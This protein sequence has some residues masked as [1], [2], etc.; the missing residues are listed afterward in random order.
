MQPYLFPYIGYFQLINY[1]DKFVFY[2]DVNY[3]KRGWINRNKILTNQKE[4]LFTVPLNKASQNNLIKDTKISNS[5]YNVWKNKTLSTVVQF[6][7]EAKYFEPTYQL[8]SSVLDDKHETISK[9]SINSITS[10]SNYLGLTTDF[11]ISSESYNNRNIIRADRLIDIC[12][13]ER[14]NTYVNPASGQ[15][16]Y[17]KNY[18]LKQGIT[19]KF[20]KP[21]PISYH[22]FN[23]KFTPWLSMID[24][25]MFNSK[26]EINRLLSGY[27]LL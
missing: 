6:Y 11:I 21:L 13:Q 7:K 5:N 18:F 10:I 15:E 9:L 2:D 17:D 3:I 24:V 19:L 20:I 27:E 23:N 12:Y 16:L 4:F 8:V 22:Q 14:I 26:E 25:L 1:V